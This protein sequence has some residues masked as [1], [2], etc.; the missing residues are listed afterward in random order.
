MNSPCYSARF[1]EPFAHLLS[2]Y[3]SYPTKSLEGLKAI[4]PDAR[5]P[6]QVAHELALDQVQ[7]TGDPD[8]GLKAA[9]VMPFGRAGALTYAMHTAATVR[10]AME[11]G[12]RYTY[13]FCDAASAR[14]DVQ[15]NRATMRFH[16]SVSLPK[17]VSDFAMSCWYLNHVRGPVSDATKL[18]CWFLNP[19]PQKT[20]EYDCTFAK[21]TLRFGAPFDGFSFSSDSL[22]AALPGADSTL[23][24]LLCEH[25]ALTAA[26]L[27]KRRTF[28]GAVRDIAMRELLHTS[29]SALDVARQLG[30]SV[31]TLGRRLGREGT[32]FSSVLDQ[33]RHELALRYVGTRELAL[34]EVAFRLRFS[35]AE[36]FYRAFKR[37][38]GQT[39]L[40][41]RRARRL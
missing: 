33:L 9:R 38:T 37:W 30:M 15:G 2:G 36:A 20:T 16:S 17:P 6:M 13:L 24:L 8:L 22:D 19:K 32:T 1:I 23:H 26:H 40:A 11:V 12:A 10:E 27:S 41:Y 21:A 14:L 25:L 35:H 31:R 34:T 5:I 18:E 29:P 39:P 7:R 4:D 28:A 3:E